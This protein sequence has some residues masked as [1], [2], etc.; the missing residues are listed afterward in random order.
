M[1]TKGSSSHVLCWALGSEFQLDGQAGISPESELAAH[2]LWIQSSHSGAPV[3]MR[4]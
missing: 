4:G 1:S 3:L 2:W